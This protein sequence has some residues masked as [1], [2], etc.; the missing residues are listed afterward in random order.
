MAHIT[1]AVGAQIPYGE[2]S[3]LRD[4]VFLS[5]GG[6]MWRRIKIWF[7]KREIRLWN[8]TLSKVCGPMRNVIIMEQQER[9]IK[10][11][12]LQNGI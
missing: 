8:E 1:D 4:P 9:R 5:I 3:H 6:I 12:E 11:L 7:L 2:L 10:L